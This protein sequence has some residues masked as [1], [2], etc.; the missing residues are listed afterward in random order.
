MLALLLLLQLLRLLLFLLLYVYP[1]L[2]DAYHQLVPFG[3]V[4]L[5]R[6]IYAAVLEYALIKVSG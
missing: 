5:A 3:F 2:L 6:A 4:M 1:R